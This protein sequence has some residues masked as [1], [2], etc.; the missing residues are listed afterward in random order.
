MHDEDTIDEQVAALFHDTVAQLRPDVSALVKG[1][2]ERGGAI[3]RRRAISTVAA[4]AV[5]AI[6]VAA[7]TTGVAT[8]LHGA[9]GEPA[10][11]G[12]T[13]TPSTTTS[14]GTPSASAPAMAHPN[15]LPSESSSK[16]AQPPIPTAQFPVKAAELPGLFA[17]IQPGKITPAEASSGRIIDDGKAGQYAHFRWNGFVTTVGFRAFPGTPAQRCQQFQQEGGPPVTC[18]QRSD[19]TV[20]VVG[21]DDV[22][23]DV[24]GGVTAR[25]AWLFTKHGYE[26]SVISYNAASMKGTPRAAH[27]PFTAAQLAQ[28]VTSPLWSSK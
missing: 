25:G 8:N 17:R 14:G 15:G 12:P 23:P 24:D 10:V 27:P 21:P 6:A 22:A 11:T 13:A 1:S 18:Q 9:W 3:R 4:A 2:V 5:A 26:I 20:L 7:V 19:G 28:T 16:P